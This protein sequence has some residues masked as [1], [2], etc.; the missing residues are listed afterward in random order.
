MLY[1]M[2]LK[3]REKQGECSTILYMCFFIMM[4]TVVSVNLLPLV[5][6]FAAKPLITSANKEAL[7]FTVSVMLLIVSTV[8]I[9]CLSYGCDRFMLKR[10]ENITAGAGDIFYYF[11]IKN[12][13][14]LICFAL[15]FSIVKSMVFVALSVPFIICAY[16]F[17]VLSAD[18]FSALVCSIFATF[19]ILFFLLSLG[20]YRKITSFLFTVRYRYIKGEYINFRHLLSSAQLDMKDKIHEIRALKR[21]FFGWFLICF[22]IAPIPYVWCY[23]R[24]TLACFAS[25]QQI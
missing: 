7:T 24:Q 23:Y 6:V 20:T 10:A 13:L 4:L 12:S 2:R 8:C 1:E 25:T 22:F 21:S 9:L 5:Y 16:T 3:G 15:R 17:Y 14:K 18:G 11:R 19:S